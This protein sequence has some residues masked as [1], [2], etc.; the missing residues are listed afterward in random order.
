[1]PRK[2]QS[3]AQKSESEPSKRK[4]WLI[5]SVLVLAVVGAPLAILAP[6]WVKNS[7]PQR[8]TLR[9]ALAARLACSPEALHMNVPPASGRYPGALLVRAPGG[10][11]VPVT[12]ENRPDD[13]AGPT[14]ELEGTAVTSASAALSGTFGGGF[15]MDSSADEWLD[16]SLQLREGRVMEAS[17][18]DLRK[19]VQSDGDVVRLRERGRAPEI[20]V[21]AYEATVDMILKNRSEMHSKQWLELK[22]AAL[23]SSAELKE[24][25]SLI[26]RSKSPSV[27]AY[28][29]LA[30]SIVSDSMAAGQQRVVLSATLADNGA[31][32]ATPKPSSART[33]FAGV[34]CSRYLHRQLG[35]L[36]SAGSSLVLMEEAMTEA[37]VGQSVSWVKSEILDKEALVT[38]AR[39]AI[40]EAKRSNAE[41]LAVYWNGH[42]VSL[43]NGQ[44]YLVMGNYEGDLKKDLGTAERR[45]LLSAEGQPLSGS[46]IDDIVRAVQAVE[47]RVPADVQG[48]VPLV[49]VHDLFAEGGLPFAIL[50][51]G[52]YPAAGMDQ[53][54]EEMYLTDWGDYFGPN[55]SPDMGKYS[56]ALG[57]FGQRPYLTSSNPVILAAKP[58]AL[59]S[60]RSHPWNDWDF[61]AGVGP[62]ASRVAR[63]IRRCQGSGEEL[64]WGRLL[65]LISDQ[66]GGVG[67]L[68][69][70]GSITW[71]DLAVFDGLRLF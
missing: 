30:I 52:C 37:G 1:M 29:T 60:V 10:L 58:G 9:E 44:L 18:P 23:K 61:S 59:A 45:D 39:S 2:P 15:R 63:N 20:V 43:P 24:D 53:L 57:I 33:V 71:S 67:E 16:V 35:D 41:A 11:L 42:S 31:S 70:T 36:P 34:A 5:P 64:T 12:F 14:F 55:R 22:N 13:F 46:N 17:L 38:W 69:V 7:N 62:L 50:V 28:E 21:R 4:R 51:D 3:P 32:K 47:D 27:V 49:A 65:S 56:K 25:G 68:S 48:L 6:G 8:V 26:L 66:K 40:S 19:R 54:R